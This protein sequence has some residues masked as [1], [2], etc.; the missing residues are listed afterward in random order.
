MK[1]RIFISAV[2]K[3]LKTARQLVANTLLALGFEPVWQDIFETHSGDIRPMLRE[4]L[5]SCSAVLQIVGDAYGAEPP[6]PDEQF[7]RVSYTQYEALYA[8]SRGKQ[9]YYLVAEANLPRD[10]DPASLDP[11]KDDA[12]D[13]LADSA[14]GK[15][16][17]QEYRAKV[18]SDEHIFIQ[19]SR[20]PKSNCRCV[21]SKM[22]SRNCAAAFAP[23]CSPSRRLWCSW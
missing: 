7:G 18:Y 15:Q 21:N 2:T 8:R 17:Q 6:A 13:S 19:C 12:A 4:K 23:G 14:S 5:D 16:L 22:N 3:E 1:P 11:P 10:A 20:I 9:V